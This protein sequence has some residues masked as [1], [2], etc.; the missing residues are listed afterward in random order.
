MI[1]KILFGIILLLTIISIVLILV[2]K[3]KTKYNKLIKDNNEWNN[4]IESRT[5]STNL[6]LENIKFNDYTLLI[7]E[8]NSTIY[9][10][11]VDV[12]NKYNPLIEYDTNK[13]A[14]IVLNNS[15][16]DEILEKN[17]SLKIM[18]YNDKYYQIYNLVVTNYPIL[19]ISYKDIE[20]NKR[21]VDVDIYIFDNH[22]YSPM[23]VVKSAGRLKIIVDHKEY[24]FSLK[25]ESLGH[26]ERENY[27]SLFGMPKQNEYLI[28]AADINNK[29][30]KYVQLFINNKYK[31]IYTFSHNGER[32]IDNFERNKENNR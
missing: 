1:K 29:N 4:I 19:N 22:I 13:K 30:E 11:V 24:S 2:L 3:H 27:I 10:S 31:G 15:I 6:Q 25:K 14:S 26:N 32:R 21:K 23:R 20:N 28:K 9:Y 16:T 7:D 18:V 5:Q 12:N 8:E 17:N